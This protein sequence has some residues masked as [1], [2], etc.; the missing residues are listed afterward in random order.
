VID[1]DIEAAIGFRIEQTIQAVLFHELRIVLM[2]EARAS[3]LSRAESPIV[4][5]IGYQ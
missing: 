3:V 5:S 1:R 2:T 4:L